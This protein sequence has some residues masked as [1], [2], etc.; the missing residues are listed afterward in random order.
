MSQERVSEK[1]ADVRGR[2]L[3]DLSDKRRASLKDVTLSLG[4]LAL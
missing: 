3:L 1:G 2:P 4:P